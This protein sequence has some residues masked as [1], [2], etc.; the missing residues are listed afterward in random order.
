[1]FEKENSE[2]GK[3]MECHCDSEMGMGLW[4]KKFGKEFQLAHLKKKEKMLEAKLEFIREINRLIAKSSSE[5]E[6]KE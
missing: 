5:P 1:M 4:A 2:K 6:E 3:G